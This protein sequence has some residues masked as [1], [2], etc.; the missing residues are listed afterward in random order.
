[1]TKDAHRRDT[2][3]MAAQGIGHDRAI[4]TDL[5]LL[6]DQFEIGALARSSGDLGTK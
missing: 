3:A 1:M 4:A 5:A 2:A 6:D